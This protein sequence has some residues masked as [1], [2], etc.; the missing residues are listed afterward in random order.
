MKRRKKKKYKLTTKYIQLK[1]NIEEPSN[2]FF[3]EQKKVRVFFGVSFVGQTES[4]GE[5]ELKAPQ[6]RI[7]AFDNEV[8]VDVGLLRGFCP[9]SE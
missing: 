3:G 1:N 4:A 7:R 6:Q 8:L 2:S 9:L 5:L